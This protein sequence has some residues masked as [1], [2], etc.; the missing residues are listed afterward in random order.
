MTHPL[1]T[2]LYYSCATAAHCCL[3]AVDP[4]WASDS[5]LFLLMMTHLRY[6][7]LLCGPPTPPTYG[8]SAHYDTVYRSLGYPCIS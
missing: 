7:L 4:F 6:E 3:S 5:I 1:L 8:L 2:W